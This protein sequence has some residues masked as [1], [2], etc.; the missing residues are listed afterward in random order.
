[1]PRPTPPRILCE[2][3]H[4]VLEAGLSPREVLVPLGRRVEYAHLE[5]CPRGGNGRAG[6]HAVPIREIARDVDDRD[7]VEHAS[8]ALD[9]AGAPLR[10]EGPIVAAA[11]DSL[12]RDPYPTSVKRPVE[13][14]TRPAGGWSHAGGGTAGGSIVVDGCADCRPEAPVH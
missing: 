13:G 7:Q 9:A 6:G 4:L 11:D 14:L 3:H 2:I 10:D 5:V 8:V 12:T 1:M